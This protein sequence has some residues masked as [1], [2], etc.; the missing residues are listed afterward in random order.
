MTRCLSCLLLGF[1]VGCASSATDD[2]P[3]AGAQ[4]HADSTP[5]AVVDTLFTA[6]DGSFQIAFPGVPTVTR[7]SANPRIAK[8]SG[9]MY[10]VDQGDRAYMVVFS[11]FSKKRT[12]A[13]KELDAGRDNTIRSLNA[14]LIRENDIAVEG[15]PG[16]DLVLDMGDGSAQRVRYFVT[17]YDL[18]QIILG[19]PKDEALTDNAERYISSFHLLQK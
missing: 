12:D 1:A 9:A 8:V 4:S 7:T 13:K 19:V 2:A 6:P 10:L 14:K 11:R 16:R 3:A 17:D 18:Y 5:A 15:Y